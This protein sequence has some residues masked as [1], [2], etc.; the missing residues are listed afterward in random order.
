MKS[1]LSSCW[2]KAATVPAVSSTEER[3][4]TPSTLTV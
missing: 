2:D 1:T 4:P 3:R